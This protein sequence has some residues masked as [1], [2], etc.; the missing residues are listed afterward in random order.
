MKRS[1]Y[2]LLTLFV[3]GG[4]AL[5]L[6]TLAQEKSAGGSGPDGS[7]LFRSKCSMCHGLDGKGFPA[8]KTPD[9][10]DPKVQAAITDKEMVTIIKEG[11]KGTAMA[12]F[13]D[14]LKED[15]IQALVK[16]IRSLNSKKAAN[17]K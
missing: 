3:V 15:E 8:I 11:K 13:A 16:Y 14:K 5:S 6:R 2:F 10:T 1:M 12:P 4:A 17:G 7:A 9:F